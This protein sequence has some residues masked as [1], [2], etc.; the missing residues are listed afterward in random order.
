MSSRRNFIKQGFLATNALLLPNLATEAKSTLPSQK[1]LAENPDFYWKSLRKS[2]PLKPEITFLNNGTMGPSPWPVI[3]ASYLSDIEINDTAH[4]G[5]WNAAVK[6]LAKFVNAEESEIALTH[7]VSEG[8]NIIAQGLP[9]K[10]G[11]EIVVSN[12]EHVGN[13]LPWLNRARI[14]KLTVKVLDYNLPDDKLLEQLD[15][16]CSKKTKVI[17]LPH[18]PCTNGRVYPINKFGELAKKYGAFFF[19]DGAH[20]AGMTK[21]DFS[22]LNCDFYASCSHKWMLGPKGTGFLYIRKD[23]LDSVNP[24]FVG[25][26]SDSGWDVLSGNPHIDGWMPQANRFFYGTQNTSNYKGVVAA[27]DFLTAIGMDNVTSRIKE[28]N[29]HLYKKLLEIDTITLLTPENAK[30]GIVSFKPQGK[31]YKDIYNR[32]MEQKIVIRA[33]PENNINCLRV[34]THIYNSFE[35]IDSFVNALN[36]LV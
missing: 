17:A 27:I 25:G 24:R 7:N 11:D 19:V 35:E 31:E 29:D 9:L 1:S 33:V 10:S 34:S 6:A 15:S 23:K 4:Y 26:H 3:Q 16:L 20:G 2:F 13:A 36:K 14:D 32:L 21:L 22:Q 12:H 8:I 28:L 5:G 18:I 30:A